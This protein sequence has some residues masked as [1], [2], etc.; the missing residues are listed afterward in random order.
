MERWS[1]IACMS[2][3][4]LHHALG[5]SNL[6]LVLTRVNVD[7]RVG[8]ALSVGVGL[9]LALLADFDVAL[10]TSLV[11]AGLANTRVSRHDG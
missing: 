6:K 10:V 1:S 11:N 3:F 9:L 7:V 2:A 5:G 8:L 4:W